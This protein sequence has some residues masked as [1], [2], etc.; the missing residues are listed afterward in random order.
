MA[1]KSVTASPCRKPR[2][3][4]LPEGVIDFTQYRAKRQA[5]VAQPTYDLATFDG[6]FRKFMDGYTALMLKENP[7]W[8]DGSS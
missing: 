4:K 5:E 1:V 8:L 7:N 2:K 3:R 6:R